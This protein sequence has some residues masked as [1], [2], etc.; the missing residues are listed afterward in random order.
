[1]PKVKEFADDRAPT[2]EEIRK[3]V[4]YNDF[5][6]KPIVYT[7]ASSGIRLGAWDY[8]KW[9]H[10]IPIKDEDSNTIVAAKLIVYAGEPEQ[11]YTFITP[12]AY[13][14]L[15]N[16]MNLRKRHGESVTSD[17]WVLRDI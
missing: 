13:A 6:I 4:E 8:I 7:M 5:R 2:I 12:E 10:V 11:H 1:M 3:L 14:A 16:W 17:S 15:D 9:K